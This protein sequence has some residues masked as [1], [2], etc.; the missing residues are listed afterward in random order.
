MAAIVENNVAIKPG[1]II[2]DGFAELYC[3]L[4]ARIL[5]VTN[6]RLDMFIIINIHMDLLAVSFRGLRV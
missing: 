4:Y 6:C 1:P 2:S 5:M 3:D